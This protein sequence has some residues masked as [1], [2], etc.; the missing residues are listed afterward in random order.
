MISL[1]MEKDNTNLTFFSYSD[2][3]QK[4]N[5]KIVFRLY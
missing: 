4:S 2:K 3:K 5:N 1:K